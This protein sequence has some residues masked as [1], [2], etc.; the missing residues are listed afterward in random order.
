MSVNERGAAPVHLVA[1]R[2]AADPGLPLNIVH[3]RRKTNMKEHIT[4]N[5]Q[6]HFGKPCVVGTRIPVQAVLELIREGL[7]FSAITQDYYPEL[8]SDDIRACV[9]YAIDV[10]AAEEI[11]LA[12]TS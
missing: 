6:V 2:P 11:H 5:P 12:P 8:E 9:Q 10:V 1:R 7:S 3:E 4:V